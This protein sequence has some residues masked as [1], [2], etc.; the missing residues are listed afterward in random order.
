MMEESLATEACLNMIK[1]VADSSYL[2]TL[3]SLSMLASRTSL[4]YPRV[5]A[6]VRGVTLTVLTGIDIVNV[7][8]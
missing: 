1:T 7:C 3:F 6:L 8:H 4:R 5:A 2:M